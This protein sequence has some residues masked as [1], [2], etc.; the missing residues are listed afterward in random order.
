MRGSQFVPSIA[1][2]CIDVLDR[3]AELTVP[4]EPKMI[5]PERLPETGSV[6]RGE[7]LDQF[8]ERER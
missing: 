8:P 4:F 2:L 6:I 5:P 7:I 3:L 1:D